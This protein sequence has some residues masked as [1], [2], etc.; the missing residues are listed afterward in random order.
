MAYSWAVTNGIT[1]W[2]TSWKMSIWNIH[3]NLGYRNIALV[4]KHKI[5]I[6]LSTIPKWLQNVSHF[7]KAIM[8]EI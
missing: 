3:G 6:A 8:G 1:I 4:R 7:D 2:S 5:Q